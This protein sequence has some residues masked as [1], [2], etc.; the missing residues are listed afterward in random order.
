MVSKNF[1][2]AF[3]KLPIK[4]NIEK[5]SPDVKASHVPP[6]AKLGFRCGRAKVKTTAKNLPAKGHHISIACEFVMVIKS[7]QFIVSENLSSLPL[8]ELAKGGGRWGGGLVLSIPFLPTPAQSDLQCNVQNQP[9]E[10]KIDDKS[11][12]AIPS[13]TFVIQHDLPSYTTPGG[14]QPTDSRSRASTAC[15]SGA[16][17][18]SGTIT[19]MTFRGGLWKKRQIFT[20]LESPVL[21]T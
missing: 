21:F 1:P 3:L 6:Q 15:M 7:C 18:P 17:T 12:G 19:V 9:G 11:H 2:N 10:G 16:A 20:Y 8:Q 13:L 4:L 14:S 5:K